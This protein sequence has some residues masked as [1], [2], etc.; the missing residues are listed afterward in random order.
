MDYVT[1]GVEWSERIL[2]NLAAQIGLALPRILSGVVIILLFLA[3]AWGLERFPIRRN[4]FGIH[5]VRL[6]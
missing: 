5:N 1:G 2:A 6:L 4:R 3:L